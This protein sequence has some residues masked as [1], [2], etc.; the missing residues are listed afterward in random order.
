[1]CELHEYLRQFS[2]SCGHL[3]IYMSI[4]FCYSYMP[5]SV[6]HHQLL[7]YE[8]VVAPAAATSITFSLQGSYLCTNFINNVLIGAGRIVLIGRVTRPTL[9]TLVEQYV[10]CVDLLSSAWFLK[11]E[12]QVHPPLVQCRHRQ[13]R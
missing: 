12:D 8:A 5:A 1:M 10:G 3:C 7:L 2:E 4:Y 11:L 6:L 13:I 9:C